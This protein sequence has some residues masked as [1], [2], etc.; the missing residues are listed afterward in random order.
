M[1]DV[2]IDKLEKNRLIETSGVNKVYEILVSI[3]IPG[4]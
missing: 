3:V 4:G 2:N 1:Y